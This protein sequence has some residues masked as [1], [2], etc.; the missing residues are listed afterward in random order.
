MD[1]KGKISFE[2][3]IILLEIGLEK[4]CFLTLVMLA[5]DCSEE[6]FGDNF[7][8]NMKSRS[9]YLNFLPLLFL[10]YFENLV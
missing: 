9:R 6:H 3:R 1:S 10:V 7:V 8:T 5:T 2:S 4:N